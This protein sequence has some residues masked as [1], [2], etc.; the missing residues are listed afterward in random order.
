MNAKNREV[1]SLPPAELKAKRRKEKKEK[2][3]QMQESGIARDGRGRWIKGVSGNDLGR[4]RTAL[5]ELC[6]AEITKHG[7]VAVL[8][9]V[10]ARKG[11]YAKKT[12]I[13]VTVA[14]QIS[15]I[16][17]LLAYGYGVPKNE[18]DAGEVRIEVSYADNRRLNV[19][20]VSE[21]NSRG[22]QPVIGNDSGNAVA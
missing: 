1:L 14:D 7:L 9:S 19:L 20:N 15:A 6:R 2:Q 17:L 13:P 10:A 18:I 12:K 22:M 4:P 16:R 5:A 8:G 11:D 21:D 3:K